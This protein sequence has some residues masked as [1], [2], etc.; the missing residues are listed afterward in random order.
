MKHGLSIIILAVAWPSALLGQ[1]T[2]GTWN[3]GWVGTLNG[4]QASYRNWSQ[5]GVNSVAVTGGT[6]FSA[7]YVRDRY[8]F[9][10]SSSLKYG[11]ARLNGNE[12]R[13]TDDEIRLRNQISRKFSNP[14]YSL[15]GQLNFDTQFDDGYDKNYVN[16]V[17]TFFAPAYVTQT[18]G[19]AYAP[20]KTMQ[21]NAGLSLKQTI[22]VD[23]LLGA[24]YGLKDDARFRN[25][26]GVSLGYRI[27]RPLAAN[28]NYTGSFDTFTNLHRPLSSTVVK[29]D[30]NVV[31]KIN[32]FLS[33]N[34]QFAMIY[35]DNVIK[36]W[37]VK[38]VLSVGFSYTI[39]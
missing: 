29:I 35:D 34:V 12:S 21:F 28:V 7:Q 27:T 4:S 37:Q 11:R 23:T 25:E 10:H 8:V 15:I 39:L 16:V 17:S 32:S 13:K 6:R 36:E 3:L 2:S 1:A 26:G 22:V 30:N 33:A 5:G 24:R 18:V 38:Q 14:S 9:D 31:G 19:F 20:D